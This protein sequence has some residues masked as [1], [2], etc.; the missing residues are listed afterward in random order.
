[1]NEYRITTKFVTMYTKE[2]Y[3]KVECTTDFQAALGAYVTY[4]Q[5]SEV[6]FCAID[7]VGKNGTSKKI[8]AAFDVQQG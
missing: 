4:I 3:N 7:V 2:E 6:V 8:I 5:N 1:M